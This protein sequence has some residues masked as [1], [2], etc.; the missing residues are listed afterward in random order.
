MVHV[1]VSL[2]GLQVLVTH[3]T[4]PAIQVV[5]Q[6]VGGQPFLHCLCQ[7][8]PLG[9]FLAPEHC[10]VAGRMDYRVMMLTKY[11]KA[12][13]YLLV[14]SFF[15][16]RNEQSRYHN[17]ICRRKISSILISPWHVLTPSPRALES[18][19]NHKLTC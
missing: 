15:L 19:R 10:T 8:G 1:P 18:Q 11:S 14:H 7:I 16:L 3:P 5:A 4:S 13:I 17:S 6:A 2:Q 12:R 9:I